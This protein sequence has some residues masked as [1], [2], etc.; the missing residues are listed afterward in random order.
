MSEEIEDVGLEVIDEHEGWKCNTDSDCEW[1]LARIRKAQA[2]HDR[3]MELSNEQIKKIQ[4]QQLRIEAEFANGTSWERGELRRYFETRNPDELN[5]TKT[6]AQTSY[7]L[8]SGTLKLKTRE[9]K[10]TVDDNTM[11]A[12]FKEHSH[13]YGAYIKVKE[14]PEWGAFKKDM[15][16]KVVGDSVVTADGEIVEGVT[17]EA[18]EPEFIIEMKGA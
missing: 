16:I 12:F 18:R 8:L 14:S 5:T 13:N 15:G 6:G 2:E 4:D 11:V 10:L 1:L 9:P 7:K 3:L 17:A